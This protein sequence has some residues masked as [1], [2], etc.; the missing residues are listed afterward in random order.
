MTPIILPVAELKSG[1]AGLG[2]VINPKSTLPVLQSLRIERTPDGWVC[3]TASDLDRFV[4]LRLEQPAKGEPL[5]MLV[6]FDDLLRLTKTCSKEERLQ[7]EPGEDRSAV[8]HF[9]LGNQTHQ[10]KVQSL[11]VEEYPVIPKVF[12]GKSFPVPDELRSAL[13]EAFACC[14]NDATRAVLHGAFLDVTRPKA[15]YVVATDGR[16]LYSSNSFHLPFAHPIIIPRH[17]FLAWR[18][19]NLD[20]PWQMKLGDSASAKSPPMVQLSSR[21]WRFITPQIE[22][23]YPNWRAVL[24]DLK[25]TLTI[26]LDASHLQSVTQAL[27]RLPCHD[28]RFHTLGLEWKQGVLSLLGKRRPTDPWTHVP[29]KT[30]KSEGRDLTVFVDREFVLKALTFGLTTLELVDELTPLRFSRGGRQMIVMPLRGD[31]APSGLNPRSSTPPP[32]GATTSMAPPPNLPP[33]AEPIRIPSMPHPEDTHT[34]EDRSRR[35]SAADVE[36][37]VPPRDPAE[38]P[39]LEAA[40]A[41]L[42]TIKAGCREAV[43]ELTRLS[44]VLKQAL[45]DQRISHRETQTMRS[46]LRS[47][48]S[49]RL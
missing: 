26:E 21:R 33:R 23:P 41:R 34:T 39:A 47:L 49:L 10:T 42:E 38:R 48:Q 16:H 5:A 24:P 25:P 20:G 29:V 19:F 13:H 8:I 6:P 17:K 18:E 40:I 14:S 43:A 30:S 32:P 4:T 7:I 37:G 45:R 1:L 9:A 36:R 3:L 15:H 22:G 44:D 28:E 11:P 35:T 2:K 31:A 46:T 12:T 27:E